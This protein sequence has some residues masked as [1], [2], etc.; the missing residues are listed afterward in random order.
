MEVIFRKDKI[1]EMCRDKTVLHLG[2]IQHADQYEGLIKSGKWLHEKISNVCSKLVGLD[3]LESDVEIIRDKY[4]YECYFADVTNLNEFNYSEK[5]DIVVCGELIEHLDNPGLMLKGIQRFMSANS[6]LII[7]TP[8]PWSKN[9]LKLIRHGVPEKKWLNPEHT[10][11]FSFQ[12]LKQILE[13]FNFEEFFY[14]YYIGEEQNETNHIFKYPLLNKLK[15]FKDLHAR[16]KDN[17]SNGLFFVSSVQSARE[18]KT[19]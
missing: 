15:K 2:F 18:Y 5:F 9:R 4:G 19:E 12:T 1:V 10:C 17:L 3:Y 13:R 14:G 8:N 7:T 16:R 11:W 6:L